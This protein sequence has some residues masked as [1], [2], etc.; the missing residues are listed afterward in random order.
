[1]TTRGVWILAAFM[2]IL[3]VNAWAA[4]EADKPEI[5]SSPGQAMTADAMGFLNVRAIRGKEWSVVRMK[6]ADGLWYA[7]LEARGALVTEFADCGN[8]EDWIRFMLW[9]IDDPD[10]R[11]LLVLRYSGGVNGPDALDIIHLKENYRTLLKVSSDF[12]LTKVEDLNS[13]GWPEVIG[14][15]RLYGNLLDLT[16]A[17]S[18]TPTLIFSYREDA[19]QYLCQNQKFREKIGETADARRKSFEQNPVSKHAFSYEKWNETSRAACADLVAWVTETCLMGDEASAWAYLQQYTTPDT[20][21]EIKAAIQERLEADPYYKAVKRTQERD[22]GV[23]DQPKV[24]P[25][26]SQTHTSHAWLKRIKPA[27]ELEASIPVG[28]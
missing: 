2:P 5:I 26:P 20:A 9:P 24:T 16:R 7:R 28:G 27:V 14:K 17:M 3:V 21:V 8:R 10:P 23:S 1:M 15:S 4:P 11:F 12:N 6:N 25:G 19:K 18:P 22:K 13:D